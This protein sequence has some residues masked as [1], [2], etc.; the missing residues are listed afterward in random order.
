MAS[1][2]VIGG[3]FGYKKLETENC[4]TSSQFPL[5]F[6]CDQKCRRLTRNSYTSDSLVICSL[7]NQNS[8]P[9]DPSNFIIKSFS[10]Y[11]IQ[12]TSTS[13]NLDEELDLFCDMRTEKIISPI[14]P[15]Q[16]CYLLKK[17]WKILNH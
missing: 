13:T 1:I 7:S 3:P 11:E 9:S 6:S 15:F 5:A 14:P 12:V 4:Y 16:F 8:Y 17:K 2:R 10:C